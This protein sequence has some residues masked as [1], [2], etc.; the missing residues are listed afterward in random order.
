V[1]LLGGLLKKVSLKGIIGGVKKGVA[2]L[3]G[4]GLVAGAVG[5]G[6]KLLK[7]VGRKNLKRAAVVGG[8][9]AAGVTAEELTRGGGGGGGGGGAGRRYR[10]IN[11]GNTRA[12]RRAIR[13]I[14]AGARI[15][16]KFFGIKRG[17]IKGA[18]GVKVKTVRFRR[19]S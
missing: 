11:P 9:A 8:V 18:P 16:S 5:V 13:R 12:M 15:Y 6:G 10:R 7:R 19:A 14:E 2:G 17:H 4:G 3:T 1:A